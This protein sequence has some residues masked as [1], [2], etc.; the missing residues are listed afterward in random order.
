[1]YIFDD[2]L[3]WFPC[4]PLET[5]ARL[6]FDR[7]EHADSSDI[8]KSHRRAR[9][10]MGRSRPSFDI[11]YSRFEVQER[12]EMNVYPT[13]DYQFVKYSEVNI[14]LPIFGAEKEATEIRRGRPGDD[15]ETHLVSIMMRNGRPPD[16]LCSSIVK[17]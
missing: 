3:T 17:A 7:L 11:L 16:L 1:M 8:V 5:S 6:L 2:A 4:P 12:G 10:A 15:A 13:L 14:R 9:L